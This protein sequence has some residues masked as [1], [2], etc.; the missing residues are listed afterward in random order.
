MRFKLR[1][2]EVFRAV[3]VTGSINGAAK[4]LFISQPAVSRIVAH[5]E[6]TLK[7]S[8]FKRMKGKLMP[9]PEANALF[10]EVEAFY[11]KAL[12]VERFAG[13]LAQGASGT[14]NV[15]CSPCLSRGLIARAVWKFV[16]RFPNIRINLKT[17]LLNEMA[18]EL[19]STKVDLAVPVLPLDNPNL[20]TE[21]FTTGRMVCVVPS[22]HELTAREN[23]G[24]R[25]VAEWPLIAHHPSIPFGQLV[26]SAFDKAGVPFEPHIDVYQTDVACALVRAGLGIAIV[27]EYTLDGIEGGLHILSLVEDIILTPSVVRSS[28]SPARGHAEKFADVLREVAGASL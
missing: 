23:I 12:Q 13:G 25:G 19:L 21:I 28:L 9:T 7:L 24:I 2:M 10:I 27:D 26:S 8:L 15:S 17:T 20:R 18:H 6:S 4:L 14:L 1:Q 11:Q 3:M 5:T 22:D 16:Q